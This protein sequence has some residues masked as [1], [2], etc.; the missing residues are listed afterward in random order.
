MATESEK[1]NVD[2]ILSHLQA[3]VEEKRKSGAYP[4]GL[5]KELAAHFE[6]IVAH[7]AKDLFAPPREELS[8]VSRSMDFD[9]RRISFD[10]KVPGGRFVH[11]LAA[12]LVARQTQGILDQVFVFA[13]TVYGTLNRLVESVQESNRIIYSDLGGQ[14]DAII[15]RLASYE[16]TPEDSMVALRDLRRRVEELEEAEASRNFRAWFSPARFEAEF[17]VSRSYE[18]YAEIYRDLAERLVGYGPVLDIGCGRGR[19]LQILR[20]LGVE[21]S[22]VD[23]DAEQVKLAQADGLRVDHGDGIEYLA[24][25]MEGSL[26]G[27]VSI[28]VVEHLTPQ[29]VAELV[30]LLGEKVR[31]GGRVIV[32]TENPQSLYMFTNTLFIDPTHFKPIHPLYLRFLFREAGFSEVEIEPRSPVPPDVALDL[33]GPEGTGNDGVNSNLAKL[34]RILFGPLTYALIA[35][36]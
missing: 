23:V 25:A 3:K 8:S 15:E 22:G 35:T 27:A 10:S 9:P 26:G 14:I 30:L 32:E 36:R 4:R 31:H 12:R 33:S 2:E 29:Q 21:A 16:R 5:E 34:N 1:P 17:Q 13:Q 7:R 24:K 6:R 28:H 20:D 18:E 19:F 11:K